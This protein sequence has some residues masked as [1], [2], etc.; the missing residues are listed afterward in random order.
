MTLSQRL[1]KEYRVLW[2]QTCK[3]AIE[4]VS[5]NSAIQVAILDIGLP[6]GDGFDLAAAI[7]KHKKIPFLFLTARSDAES[8]LRGWELGAEEF[9]PK[10]FHLKELLLRLEHVLKDHPL[11]EEYQYSTLKIR[12]PEN[13][14]QLGE[15]PKTWLSASETKLLEVL[16][17]H[18]PKVMSRDD[19][20]NQVWGADKNLSH[21]HI[22]NQIVKLRTALGPFGILIKTVRGTGYQWSTENEKEEV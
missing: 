21:R 19:L 5:Q 12:F 22:D 6:D 9:I 2:A 18:S 11:G 7:Q 4:T 14:L 20:M 3:S 15:G 17:G 13:S 1:Q 10:P 16:I 8:R